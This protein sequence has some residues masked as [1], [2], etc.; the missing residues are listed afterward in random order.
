MRVLLSALFADG[1]QSAQ[2]PVT[3]PGQA[4]YVLSKITVQPEFG[5]SKAARWL[6]RF[7]GW[8]LGEGWHNL[9]HA[10]QWSVRQGYGVRGGRIRPL[11]DPTYVFIRGLERLGWADRLRLPAAEDL[12]ER[13]R[14]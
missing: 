4:I 10:F 7:P 8:G 3:A 1:S 2:I 11:P 5:Q 13:A 14:P 9:H 6:D 12:L